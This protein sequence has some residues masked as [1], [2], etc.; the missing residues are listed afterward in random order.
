M[1][2]PSTGLLGILANVYR[3]TSS[4]GS[5]SW[6]ACNLISDC[7][8]KP[9]WKEADGSTRQ[10]ISELTAKTR[11]ALEVSL[12][13]RS[14]TADANY[15]AFFA[16]LHSTT[17]L[18]LMILNGPSNLNG[19]DG[20]R[21]DWHVFAGEEDQGLDAVAFKAFT[22]KPALSANLPYWVLVAAGVPVF[23]LPG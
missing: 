10:S 2:E 19:V 3:N 4:Y 22:L 14:D 18:D 23:T 20:W 9:T 17:V 13:M 16:A 15:Q 12:K 7:S 11:L 5:P 1:S 6:S 8:V 21:A